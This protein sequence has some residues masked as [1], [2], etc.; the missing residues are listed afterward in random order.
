M[1]GLHLAVVPAFMAVMDFLGISTLDLSGAECA[2]NC[3][4]YPAEMWIGRTAFIMVYILFAS[5]KVQL[6][7][8]L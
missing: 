6:F 3:P 7:I 2:C 8:C 5:K 1:C 4:A